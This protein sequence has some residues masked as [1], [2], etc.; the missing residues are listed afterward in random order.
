LEPAEYQTMFALEN[1]YWWFVARRDLVE[2]WLTDE[3]ATPDGAPVD[4]PRKIFDIG[5][6][7]GANGRMLARFGDVYGTDMAQEALAFS[8]Q[9]GL[10]RLARSRIESLC[11]PENTFDIITALDVLEHVDDDLAG[12]GEVFRVCKPGG[13]LLVT[14]PAYGFLWSEHDEALHHRRRYTASELRN[15]LSV[16][17]FDIERIS[18][19]ISLLFLPVLALRFWQNLRKRSVRPQTGLIIPPPFVN[20]LLVWLLAF[21]RLLVRF[22]NLPLGVSI[23]CVARKPKTAPT[24]ATTF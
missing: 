2:E 8:R 20:Q 12:L 16:S 13:T 14:V 1:A 22:F 15:K 7:T 11:F 18:Y 19:F 9:R 4:E 6:G 10:S 21:E 5:C 17:G 23:I 3:L 24:S